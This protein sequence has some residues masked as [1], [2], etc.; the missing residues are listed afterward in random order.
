MCLFSSPKPAK[1]PE[2]PR[3]AEP[4]ARAASMS[5]EEAR[6]RA[7]AFGTRATTLTSPL[8]VS[9]YGSAS[10]GVTLLGRAAV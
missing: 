5:D 6:R 3:P 2:A 9:N 1:V 4:E 8:G 10:R 7:A